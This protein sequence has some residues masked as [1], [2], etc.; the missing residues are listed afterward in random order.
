MHI[1][2]ISR[3]T[4][5][6]TN[7]VP[8]AVVLRRTEKVML[9]LNLHCCSPSGGHQPHELQ[10][11]GGPALTFHAVSQLC[12]T[13]TDARVACHGTPLSATFGSIRRA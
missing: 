1:L 12:A 5:S 11:K 9:R 4:D 8:Q 13:L 3:T 2:G 6:L 7:H 10:R